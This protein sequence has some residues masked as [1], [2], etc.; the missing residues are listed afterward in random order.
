MPHSNEHEALFLQHLPFIDRAAAGAAQVVGLRGDDVEEFVSWAREQLWEDD[1]ALVRKWRGQSKFTTYLATVIMNL[2]REYRVK[3][4]GRWRPSAAAL[5][6]GSLAVRLETL[7]YRDGWQ[8]AEAAELVRS[9]G[10]T[11]LST[12]EIADLVAK[13]PPRVR[14]PRIQ[15]VDESDMRN[16]ADVRVGESED[17]AERKAIHV[18]LT[19]ALSELEPAAQVVVKMHF[20]EGRSLADVARA[21]CLQQKPLYRVKD[22]ALRSLRDRLAHAGITWGTLS[23]LIG[24]DLDADASASKQN[25]ELE[26]AIHS[27]D[28]ELA[29]DNA[30]SRPSNEQVRSSSPDETPDQ[31]TSDGSSRYA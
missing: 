24:G 29:R 6:L 20:L 26:P 27:P 7:V 25:V 16:D 17:D 12:R 10:E 9:R 30:T 4:W 5:R 15:R 2:G 13:I 1:Y 11:S 19:S 31:G 28:R 21:L 14:R 8:V 23:D 22:A 3:L 18:A